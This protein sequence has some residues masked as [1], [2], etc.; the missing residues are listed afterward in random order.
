MPSPIMRR[1]SLH[2]FASNNL[3]ALKLAGF[4]S[5]T[6]AVE[7]E[8]APAKAPSPSVNSLAIAAARSKRRVRRAVVNSSP[9]NRSSRSSG[10]NADGHDAGSND[11][12]TS[13]VGGSRSPRRLGSPSTRNTG[14][15]NRR[16]LA[17]GSRALGESSGRRFV[18]TERRQRFNMARLRQ[19]ISAAAPRTTTSQSEH[20]ASTSSPSNDKPTPPTRRQS[21]EKGKLLFAAAAAAAAATAT[22]EE[23]EPL[24]A[25][26]LDSDAGSPTGLSSLTILNP[27]EYW[28]CIDPRGANF[29]LRPSPEALVGDGSGV[30][31]GETLR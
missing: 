28:K 19:D 23:G 21:A 22:L 20:D 26:A 27:P 14:S 31:P 24:A 13:P 29:R 1:S 4:E 12:T 25:E 2:G 17:A 7:G 11:R 6:S 30:D 10:G 16:G 9:P 18:D 15:S 5:P 8:A 3:E